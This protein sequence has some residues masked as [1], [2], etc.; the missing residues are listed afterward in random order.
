MIILAIFFYF[1][2]EQSLSFDEFF[3][4]DDRIRFIIKRSDSWGRKF[5]VNVDR[6][7]II[8]EFVFNIRM[9]DEW[10]FHQVLEEFIIL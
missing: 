4:E 2:Q 10:N 1:L 7:T 9:N 5:K 8:V 3:I 6:G